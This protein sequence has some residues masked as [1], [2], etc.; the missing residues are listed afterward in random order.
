[1]SF[2]LALLSTFAPRLLTGLGWTA[3]ITLVSV[4]A[5]AFWGLAL[6][7]ARRQWRGLDLAVAI[8]VAIFRGTPLLIQLFLLYYGG[9]SLG[10]TLDS[11]TTGLVGLTL[12]GGAY[13]SEIF[14]AGFTAVPA[15]QEE[16]ARSLGLGRWLTFRLI[17]LPQLLAAVIPPITNQS[18][19]LLKESA[20]LSVIT[21]PELTFETTRM[22]TETFSVLEPYLAIALLY[23]AAATVVSHAGQHAEAALTRHLS[24]PASGLISHDT[25]EAIS[26]PAAN[27]DEP[28]VRS[29]AE[30]HTC[31]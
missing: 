24:P 2:D 6:A 13:F 25:P 20:V 10:L 3:S 12:Y 28:H 30:H 23:W 11:T 19:I 4:I 9:P 27:K 17:Q 7:L 16:A 15:G 21:V 5:G 8:Y 22:V 31:S 14:R 18:I 26:N 1:V 29:R